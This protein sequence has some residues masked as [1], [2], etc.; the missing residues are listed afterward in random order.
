MPETRRQIAEWLL[1]RLPG[2]RL[3]GSGTV[4]VRKKERKAELL[5]VP[6]LALPKVPGLLAET[7]KRYPLHTVRMVM[8]RGKVRLQ[9]LDHLERRV[10]LAAKADAPPPPPPPPAPRRAPPAAP[11]PRPA[12][13]PPPRPPA[14]APP[15]QPRWSPPTRFGRLRVQSRPG[16]EAIV[17]PLAPGLYVVTEVPEQATREYGIAPFIPAMTM[18]VGKLFKP[19][20]QA[21]AQP[22]VVVVAAPAQPVAPAPAAQP[23]AQ[24]ILPGPAPAQPAALPRPWHRRSKAP[25]PDWVDE[26]VA[27]FAGLEV[28]CADCHGRCGRGR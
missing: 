12:P 28:G 5:A 2:A 1:T 18:A 26:E 15:A 6:T 25:L 24:P 20:P 21:P 9:V 11:A 3:L 17:M 13:R 27:A 19:Q 22:Q 16:T 7:P 23:G 10:P 8:W 14:P 4:L